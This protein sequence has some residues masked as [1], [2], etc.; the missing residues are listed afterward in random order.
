[1]QGSGGGA[2]NRLAQPPQE[3]KCIPLDRTLASVL[4]VP[5]PEPQAQERGAAT[6]E[7]RA[8]PRLCGGTN[9]SLA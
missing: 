7:R 4:L 6:A 8:F 3:H 9:C 1:M 2:S 5:A